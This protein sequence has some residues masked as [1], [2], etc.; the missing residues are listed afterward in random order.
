VAEV[1]D[2]H[3][4]RKAAMD[5]QWA[6]LAAIGGGGVVGLKRGMNVGRHSEEK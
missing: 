2:R 5:H 4:L 1:I 6:G 3:W